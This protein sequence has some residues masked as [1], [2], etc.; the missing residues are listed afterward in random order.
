MDSLD[1]NCVA[2]ILSFLTPSE[3]CA[4]ASV[5]KSWNQASL[6][7]VCWSRHLPSSLL[8]PTLQEIPEISLSPTPVAK[9]RA[10][11]GG[12]YLCDDSFHLRA[13]PRTGGITL[14]INIAK[15]LEVAWL[16]D[17]RYWEVRPADQAIFPPVPFLRA[18]CWFHVHGTVKLPFQLPPAEYSVSWRVARERGAV[19][20]TY[21]TGR[22]RDYWQWHRPGGSFQWNEDE[23]ARSA[24]RVVGSSSQLAEAE[25]TVSYRTVSPLSMWRP[26]HA[27]TLDL[28][29]MTAG[30]LVV[31]P[32]DAAVSNE[33]TKNGVNSTGS[34]PTELE[35]SL[36]ETT[37]GQWKKGL[38]LD[39]LVLDQVVPCSK[40]GIASSTSPSRALLNRH[41]LQAHQPYQRFEASMSVQCTIS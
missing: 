38:Y 35:V 26:L 37:S 34:Q 11:C 19:E 28:R 7:D 12:I 31:P 5:C 1:E 18:V 17:A 16:D 36:S 32:D 33:G 20:I 3:I 10:L 4:V 14:S 27:G 15:N 6:S 25:V 41:G 21:D 24:V 22:E 23:K 9:Y 30:K 39:A 8:S 29:D 13:N 2:I 40:S